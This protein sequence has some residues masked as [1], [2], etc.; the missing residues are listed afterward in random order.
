[1]RTLLSVVAAGALLALSAGP[2]FAQARNASPSR[3]PATSADWPVFGGDVAHTNVNPAP[4]PMNAS[5]AASLVRRQIT[6]DGI[7]DASVIY[8]KGVT[9]GGSAH[10]TLFATTRYGETMAV[11]VKSGAILWKFDA[12]GFDATAT[13][14]EITNTTPV[15][16][17]NRQSIYTATSDGKVVKLS[18]ANGSAQWSTS[19]TKL[20]QREKIASPLTYYQGHIFAATAGYV[21]DAPPYQGHIVLLDA[22]SGQM[23]H[24]WNSLCSD[25]HEIIDPT[26]CTAT[27]S[28][29]WG[30]AGVVI[31]PANGHLFVST[32]NGPWDGQTSW[33][34]ATIELNEN[35]TEILGNWT[36]TNNEE[37][38][39]RDLDIGSTSPVLLGDGYIAQGGKDGTIRLL[40]LDVLK[41]TAPHR[42]GELQVV[43]TPSKAQL[44]TAPAVLKVNGTTWM[45]AAD[46]GAT[47]AWTFG[48]DHQLKEAW[49]DAKGGTSPTIA[50]G[51]LFVYDPGATG[52]IGAGRAGAAGAPAAPPMGALRVYE[53]TTGKLVATLEC[54][55]GHWNSP[56]V[57]DGRV[58]LPEGSAN[59][60]DTAA[61]GTINVWTLP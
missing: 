11:D 29:I 41:G 3:P 54:G 21:G 7:I 27:R 20:A 16:D 6:V 8:L 19:I 22:G 1:M 28:A 18:I 50:G 25:R 46:R 30:R 40:T 39:R 34:D 59:N 58:I 53:A 10:D 48:A 32:G 44:L 43:E 15:A 33:G 42:G 49:K 9:V 17:P 2:T 51:L 38:Q 31:D 37:L 35:A 14:R 26:S 5:N 12:P 61:K 60:R 52:G 57:A 4:S 24:V 13:P 56:I 23:Q 36:T 47:A 45:F 55:A